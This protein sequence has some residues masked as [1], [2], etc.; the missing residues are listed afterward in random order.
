MRL[1]ATQ[2]ASGLR[3]VRSISV[4]VSLLSS[5]VATNRA[6]RGRAGGLERSRARFSHVTIC[7][8]ALGFLSLFLPGRAATAQTNGMQ[9]QIPSAEYN[10]LVDLYNATSG[11]SWSNQ[12]GW[13]NPQATS[14]Y[15]V[16]VSGVQYDTN[17]NVVAAGN[18][19]TLNLTAN[20]L[21]GNLPT[22][23]GALSQLGEGYSDAQRKKMGEGS[24][25]IE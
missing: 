2:F 18:V 3:P 1:T 11:S 10:A 9:Y 7:A 8:V 25:S 19:T 12:T 17:G 23:L 22:S 16:G 13:L 14:W 6:I 4:D 20:Q 21:S 5:P 15:G 24:R